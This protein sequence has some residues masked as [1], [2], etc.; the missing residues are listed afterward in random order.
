MAPPR[1]SSSSSKILAEYAK[2]NRSSCKKCTKKIDANALRLA[3]V[4]KD[5]RGYD[6]VK[7]HHLDCFPVDSK[8]LDSPEAIE[9]FSS[10]KV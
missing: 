8:L 3:L 2:S 9:G 6:L 10:L 7:W 1:S 5:N 4:T